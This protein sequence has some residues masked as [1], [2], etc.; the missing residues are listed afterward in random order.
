MAVASYYS[1]HYHQMAAQ[2]TSVSESFVLTV[3]L[4][5]KILTTI[6]SLHN[7]HSIFIKVLHDCVMDR[8]VFSHALHQPEYDFPNQMLNT[9]R[10]A[11]T[12]KDCSSSPTEV[13]LGSRTVY[14][15][16]SITRPQRLAQRDQRRGLEQQ[17]CSQSPRTR[18]LV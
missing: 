17:L 3:N 4:I 18:S 14:A 11:L 16:H 8:Q 13:R 9:S 15:R 6:P 12:T 7:S 1:S 5:S 2:N 10:S